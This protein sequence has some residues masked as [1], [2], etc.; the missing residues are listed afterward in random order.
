VAS[1][2]FRVSSGNVDTGERAVVVVGEVDMATAPALDKELAQH[3]GRVVV[4]L[5]KV[6]FMDSSGIR[7]LINHKRRLEEA[8]GQ[9]RLLIATSDILRLFELTGLADT[10][11][12]DSRLHPEK[13]PNDTEP[14]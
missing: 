5:R 14:S 4:D 13:S 8:G 9:I 11:M 12:I 10:F 3:R 1:E 7:V 2:D 6:P